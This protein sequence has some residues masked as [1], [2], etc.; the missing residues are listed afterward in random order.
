MVF[1]GVR[2]Q[3]PPSTT[4]LQFTQEEMELGRKPHGMGKQ[5]GEKPT[6]ESLQEDPC[7]TKSPTVMTGAKKSGNAAGGASQWRTT[8]K[9]VHRGWREAE[10]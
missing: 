2:G 9:W 8:R 5:G 6:L 3:S 1:G 4:W 7:S 10:G